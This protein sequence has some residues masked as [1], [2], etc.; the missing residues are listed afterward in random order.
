MSRMRWAEFSH[1]KNAKEHNITFIFIRKIRLTITPSFSL[2]VKE[3]HP[4]LQRRQTLSVHS[5]L[6]LSLI[7]RFS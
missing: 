2:P 5:E 6:G 4:A 1:L 7:S 3:T